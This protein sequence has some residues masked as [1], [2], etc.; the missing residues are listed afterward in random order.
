MILG[1]RRGGARERVGIGAAED[2]FVPAAGVDE[3]Q[4]C[5]K[6]VVGDVLRQGDFVLHGLAPAVAEHGAKVVGEHRQQNPMS[7]QTLAGRREHKRDV[8]ELFVVEVRGELV[9]D[10]VG[11]ERRHFQV[12][13]RGRVGV[14]DEGVGLRKVRV[15]ASTAEDEKA[16][17]D[18]NASMASA[19]VGHTSFTGREPKSLLRFPFCV[20]E[21][22][23]CRRRFQPR[24]YA[25]VEY[26][27]VVEALRCVAAAPEEV[28][29]AG[30]V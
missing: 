24:A 10:G 4:D 23:V 8:A 17:A 12:H 1:V 3:V 25:R 18:R 19:T 21:L 5:A 28:E 2:L 26:V 14:E 11:H 22:R 29:Q 30:N 20:V 9:A 27:A 7:E 16:T 6:H 15:A 13:V